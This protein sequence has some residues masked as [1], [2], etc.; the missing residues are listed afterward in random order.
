MTI[1]SEMGGFRS[2]LQFS[3]IFGQFYVLQTQRNG[4]LA[5]CYRS[6]LGSG[7]VVATRVDWMRLRRHEHCGRDKVR[8]GNWFSLWHF[9]EIVRNRS[10]QTLIH[11]ETLC[12]NRIQIIIFAR[13]IRMVV[14]VDWN[15]NIRE[16]VLHV[17]RIRFRFAIVHNAMTGKLFVILGG[18]L[19]SIFEHFADHRRQC[20]L[21]RIGSLFR[22]NVFV[23]SLELFLTFLGCHWCSWFWFRGTFSCLLRRC[24]TSAIQTFVRTFLATAASVLR[25]V[26]LHF[27]V[28]VRPINKLVAES[29]KGICIHHR[30]VVGKS[31]RKLMNSIELLSSLIR[32]QVRHR[33]SPWILSGYQ[34]SIHGFYHSLWFS[35]SSD[36]CQ[37]QLNREN[38]SFVDRADSLDWTSF[39]K[40]STVILNGWQ[41]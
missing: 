3:K 19:M 18:I 2:G 28:C 22:R 23:V 8:I 31:K 12:L 29:Y 4:T 32:S 27:M 38:R 5:S 17:D 7:Q 13:L 30:L 1:R 9:I 14:N 11:F 34:R 35:S 26:W 21:T 39:S 37:L 25:L 20:L 24:F 33:A 15:E 40:L 10:L 36:D 41:Q 6:R 16:S